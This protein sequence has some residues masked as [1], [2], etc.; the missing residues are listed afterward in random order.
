MLDGGATPPQQTI[1]E[2]LVLSVGAC[3][4]DTSKLFYLVDTADDKLFESILSTPYH[5][6]HA[7]YRSAR[8]HDSTYNLCPWRHD[9]ILSQSSIHLIDANFI[10]RQL[11]YSRIVLRHKVVT[12]LSSCVYC[13]LPYVCICSCVLTTSL[14]NEYGM[15]WYWYDMIWYDMVWYGI[16]F[17]SVSFSRT[18]QLGINIARAITWSSAARRWTNLLADGDVQREAERV[19]DVDVGADH[20]TDLSRRRRWIHVDADAATIWQRHVQLHRAQNSRCLQ[21]QHASIHFHNWPLS[22]ATST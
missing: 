3:V 1:T 20:F 19:F 13:V 7:Y 6:L 2:S 8:H 21:P 12:I 9:R 14:I 17:G 4:L 10:I 16:V 15:I 22:T 18:Y 11:S 5:V